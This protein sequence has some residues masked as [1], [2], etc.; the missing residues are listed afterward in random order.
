MSDI[1]ETVEVPVLEIQFDKLIQICESINIVDSVTLFSM[2]NHSKT[3]ADRSQLPVSELIS[4]LLSFEDEENKWR[5]N[6]KTVVD[7]VS[8]ADHIQIGDKKI[9]DSERVVVISKMNSVYIIPGE[10]SIKRGGFLPNEVVKLSNLISSQL[11]LLRFKDIP[12]E[13]EGGFDLKVEYSLIDRKKIQNNA[14]QN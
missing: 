10:Q 8:R 13:K 5:V 3:Y 6:H 12:N 7:L 4:T 14:A 11:F 2:P 9:F 1:Q